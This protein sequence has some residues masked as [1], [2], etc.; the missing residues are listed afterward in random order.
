M[1]DEVKNV[2]IQQQWVKIEVEFLLIIFLRRSIKPIKLE[3]CINKKY[4]FHISQNITQFSS[5]EDAYITYVPECITMPV[6]DRVT[7]CERYI[8]GGV[9]L[10]SCCINAAARDLSRGVIFPPGCVVEYSS[11]GYREKRTGGT[12]NAR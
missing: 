7:Q 4:I 2:D 12:S 8:T 3:H 9:F 5:R 1:Q 6:R 10:P 11:H